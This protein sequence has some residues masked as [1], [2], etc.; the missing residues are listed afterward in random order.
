[1][2]RPQPH[3]RT[4]PANYVAGIKAGLELIGGPVGPPRLPIQPLPAEERE[5]FAGI[6]RSAGAL[7]AVA[8]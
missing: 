7:P 4:L 3:A 1:M 2:N 6:L 5:R 8:A